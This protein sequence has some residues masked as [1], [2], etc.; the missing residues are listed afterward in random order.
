MDGLTPLATLAAKFNFAADG[1]LPSG[2]TALSA[3]DAD[4]I[5]YAYYKATTTRPVRPFAAHQS[6]ITPPISVASTAPRT[7]RATR[8]SSNT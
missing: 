1:T 3:I 8:A 4:D 6:P 7:L 2:T 5:L